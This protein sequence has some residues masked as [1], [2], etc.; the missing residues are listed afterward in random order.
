[1]FEKVR[2]VIVK[3]L[4]LLDTDITPETELLVDLS[5]NSLDLVELV[6]A[7]ETEFDIFVPEK[8]I[9]KFA[10]VKDIVAYL[11]QRA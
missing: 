4:H 5:V 7:F 1:M 11:E 9:R 2:A 6:C 10:K 3:Q 8:D